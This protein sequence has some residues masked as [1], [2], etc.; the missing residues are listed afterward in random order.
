MIV[1]A[2]QEKILTANEIRECV[3]IMQS[4]GRYSSDRLYRDILDSLG[5]E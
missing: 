3:N 1:V 2:Y 4:T 5:N